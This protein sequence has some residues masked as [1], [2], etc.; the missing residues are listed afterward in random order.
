MK[1]VFLGL[2][3]PRTGTFAR[4]PFHDLAKMTANL[5]KSLSRSASWT[6]F[7]LL[8]PRRKKFAMAG[9]SEVEF[10]S[11]IT[12]SQGEEEQAAKAQKKQLEG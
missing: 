9:G 10:I 6:F 12:L 5:L 2:P 11:V 7:T 4:S 3:P 8:A 1:G